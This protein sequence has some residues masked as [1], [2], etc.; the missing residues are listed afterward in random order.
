MFAHILIIVCVYCEITVSA[1]HVYFDQFSIHLDARCVAGTV[2][3]GDKTARTKTLV[4]GIKRDG[5]RSITAKL[6]RFRTS[7]RRRA[8]L[9]HRY[10]KDVKQAAK[11]EPPPHCSDKHATSETTSS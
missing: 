6:L 2:R 7:A 10:A 8:S 4:V 3:H 11:K 9:V 5:I 1:R